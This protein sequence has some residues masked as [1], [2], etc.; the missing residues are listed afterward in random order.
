M[1]NSSAKDMT[2][3]IRILPTK[4]HTASLIFLHGL[5]DTGHGWAAGFKQ[6]KLE[7]V[8]CVCP[9]A[10]TQAVTMNG[11]MRMPSWFDLMGLSPDS[12]EDEEGIKK[13]SEIL[14]QLIREEE[15]RGIPSNKI[16]VGGF[17]QG[18][19]VSLYTALC[20]YGKPLAGVIGLSTW[21]PL[22]KKFSTI[23]KGDISELPVFLGHGYEDPLVPYKWSQETNSQLSKILKHIH[24]KSYHMMHSSCDEE[25]Q[26]LK[27]FLEKIA[28]E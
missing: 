6:L 18:G 12:P 25:M 21:L 14:K 8:Q 19:A 23:M 5:G 9:T 20:S 16:F 13:S 4:K 22:H 24:Y 2:A 28:K 1:G 11:G 15:E 27:E 26:D 7:H 3:P 10:P 17:S